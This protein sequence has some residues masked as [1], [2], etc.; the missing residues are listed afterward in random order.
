MLHGERFQLDVEISLDVLWEA[1]S[2][3]LTGAPP[4]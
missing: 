3:E 1:K 4:G 2:D